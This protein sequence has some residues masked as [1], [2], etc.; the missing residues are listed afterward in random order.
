V[1]KTYLHCRS[2]TEP[3]EIH[4]DLHRLNHVA[5]MV[6]VQNQASVFLPV[7]IRSLIAAP[8]SRLAVDPKTMAVACALHSGH[9]AQSAGQLQLAVELFTAVVAA[10]EGG[11][12]V[13]YVGEASRMLEY[14]EQKTPATEALPQ[15]AVQVSSRCSNPTHCAGG[16]DRLR[17][18]VTP[19]KFAVGMPTDNTTHPRTDDR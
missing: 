14:L 18:F 11:A 3:D 2:N 13:Y 7:A 6:S 15:P 5:H 16:R 4:A 9:V 10:Q 17:M 19:R 8:P 12:P 1:W